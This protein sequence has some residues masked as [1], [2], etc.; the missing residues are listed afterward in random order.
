LERDSETICRPVALDIRTVCESIL[1]LLPN[2]DDEAVVEI[3]VV[4]RP[5]VPKSIL[6]DETYIYRIL[7]NLL[8]NALK[9]TRSGYI[10]L[11][12][13]VED[14]KLMVTVKDTG[15]GIP[16]SFLPQLFEPF[17]QAQTRGSQRGTGLGL[18]IV[19]QLLHNMNGTISVESSYPEVDRIGPGQSGSTF[20][21][22]IP[23]QSGTP[24]NR[25]D[26]T[27]LPKIAI[28]HGG[29]EPSVEGLQIA[30][31][32]FEFEVVIANDFPDLSG[33]E[34][35]YIWADLPFLKA[36]PTCLEALL[37]QEKWLVL[38][39]CDNLNR[40]REIPELESASQFIPLPRPLL[41]HSFLQR[42]A[43][44]KQEPGQRE[45]S[46]MVRFAS[47]VDFVNENEE[48]Q[49]QKPPA[50]NLLILLVEDNPVWHLSLTRF[51]ESLTLRLR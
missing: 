40:F 29:N 33:V 17:K 45:V 27:T 46:R 16:P 23:V 6:L 44:A 47:E 30:W 38:V 8:S 15:P 19:K 32:K 4:V 14:G 34:W 1:V 5:D 13:E 12:V 51:V 50:K 31:E 11:L 9:F 48:V 21:I 7:M 39:P 37:N 18:S 41:W 36:N 25:L 20:T 2:K 42:I 24:T 49:I 35:Q 28:F 26:V 43:A 3:I 10:L 22:S